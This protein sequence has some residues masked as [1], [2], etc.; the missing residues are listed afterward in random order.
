M[1]RAF[2]IWLMTFLLG[3]VWHFLYDWLPI[4]PVAI[5]APVN[6]SVWEH[7]KLLYFPV[8]AVQG[9]LL[10]REGNGERL[11]GIAAAL[12]AMPLFLLGWYYIL[13]SGFGVSG[14]L[15]DIG[16]YAVTLGIG[17]GIMTFLERHGNPGAGTL[18]ALA[19]IY[20]VVLI[21]LTFGAP[22]LPVFLE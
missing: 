19:A 6:E 1:K 12:L 7:L 13:L 11:G 14:L 21:F 10:Y 17:Q 18:V 15:L 5:V 22:E 3:C 16:L 8:V 4:L 2:C 9:I 20:G